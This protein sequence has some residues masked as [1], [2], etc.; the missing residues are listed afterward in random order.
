MASYKG[1][2]VAVFMTHN[3]K[4]C[5]EK[6]NK[7]REGRG[8][9]CKRIARTHNI[10]MS[11]CYSFALIW[12]APILNLLI[13]SLSFSHCK[14]CLIR[15]LIDTISEVDLFFNEPFFCIIYLVH[16]MIDALKGNMWR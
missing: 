12:K 16:H 6:H 13:E 1:R 7:K 2:G 14:T 8:S 11:P 10:I 4:R 15:Q 9:K 5:M 3:D